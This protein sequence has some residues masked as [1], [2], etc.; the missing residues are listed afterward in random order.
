MRAARQYQG[1]TS[2]AVLAQVSND[3]GRQLVFASVPAEV[4]SQTRRTDFDGERGAMVAASANDCPAADGLVAAGRSFDAESPNLRRE[5]YARPGLCRRV[6]LSP[7]AVSASDL[8]TP[9]SGRPPAPQ[10]DPSIKAYRIETI[11]KT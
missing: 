1:R 2:E 10:P 11:D 4:N 3:E 7:P 8:T 5:R 6:T 9:P